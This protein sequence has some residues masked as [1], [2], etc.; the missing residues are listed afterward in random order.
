MTGACN[1]SGLFEEQT[2][3]HFFRAYIF[4]LPKVTNGN[5]KNGG[6]SDFFNEE[7]IDVLEI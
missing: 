6:Y 5:A 7:L 2:V 1:A 4:P 3:C